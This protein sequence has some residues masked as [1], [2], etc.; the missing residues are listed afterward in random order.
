MPKMKMS[1]SVRDRIKITK[2]GKVIRRKVGQRHLKGNKRAT[3]VR[4]GKE[5]ILVHGPIEKK[6][7]KMLGR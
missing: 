4:R 6:L 7:K 1:K 2:N 3:N 5:P